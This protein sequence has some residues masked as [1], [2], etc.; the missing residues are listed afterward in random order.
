MEAKEVVG[1]LGALAHEHRLAV[2]RLLVAAGPDGLPAGGIAERLGMAPSSMAFHLQTLLHAG[3]VSQRRVSRQVFY[4]MVPE[5]VNGL[6]AY[7]TENCCGG[8]V[9]CAPVC[10]PAAMAPR[11][12]GSTSAA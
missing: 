3:L 6:V 10:Q 4:A 7:L 12:G 8:T 11:R 5:A 9:A 2:Y 1:A